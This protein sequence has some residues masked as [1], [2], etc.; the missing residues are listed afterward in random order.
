ML[1]VRYLELL[2]STTQLAGSKDCLLLCVSILAALLANL[3][4]DCEFQSTSDSQPPFAASPPLEAKVLRQLHP[5][6]V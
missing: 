6:S 1:I 4:L 3:T 5:L 2:A